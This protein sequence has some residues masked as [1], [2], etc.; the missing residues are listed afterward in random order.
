[1]RSL[2][3]LSLLLAARAVPAQ[4]PPSEVDRAEVLRLGDMVQHVNGLGQADAGAYVD[5]MGPPANDGDKWF[6]SVV[7]MRGCAGCER[8]KRDWTTSPWLLALANPANPGQSWAHFNVYDKDDQ[9]QAFRFKSLRITVYPTIVV[10]PPR[11]G[12]YGDPATVVF[13]GTYTGDPQRLARDISNAIRRYLARLLAP[14]AEGG[15]G[16]LAADPPWQP[17]PKADP[18]QPGPYPAFPPFDPTIPPAPPAPTPAPVPTPTP[19]PAPAPPAATPSILT[20][21][22]TGL[23]GPAAFALGYAVLMYVRSRRQAAGKQPLL[24]QASLDKVLALLKQLAES[25]AQRP[26]SVS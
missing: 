22:M 10:Q 23:S 3:V 4:A 11:S 17:V 6:V 8:L 13:Q 1:M 9:S 5:A 14:D 24:D 21:L 20:L 16:Q 12:K 19:A 18:T 26:T 7:T 25:Q 2:I 15:H